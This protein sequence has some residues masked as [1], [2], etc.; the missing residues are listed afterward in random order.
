VSPA[1]SNQSQLS[2]TGTSVLPDGASL[3]TATVVV[4]VVLSSFSTRTVSSAVDQSSD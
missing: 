4:A 2:G 3:G 1:A